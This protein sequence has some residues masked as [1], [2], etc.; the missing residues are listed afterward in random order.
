MSVGDYFAIIIWILMGLA[1]IAISLIFL[2]IIYGEKEETAESR[3]PTKPATVADRILQIICK[4]PA[5]T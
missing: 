1:F 2:Y 5:F 4:I 3:S